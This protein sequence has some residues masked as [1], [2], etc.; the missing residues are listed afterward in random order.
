MMGC[1][2]VIYFA[3]SGCTTAVHVRDDNSRNITSY[4]GVLLLPP[5][6]D[7]LPMFEVR[8]V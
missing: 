2:L 6:S 5:R 3:H 8:S 4:R 1:V 7:D